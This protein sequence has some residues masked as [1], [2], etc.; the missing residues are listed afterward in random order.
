[1]GGPSPST[2]AASR[3]IFRSAAACRCFFRFADTAVF[4]RAALLF[5]F[6][7]R[8]ARDGS[9]STADALS[10]SD[11]LPLIANELERERAT[12]RDTVF[13]IGANGAAPESWGPVLAAEDVEKLGYTVGKAERLHLRS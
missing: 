3:A 4:S 7:R 12:L 5:W 6:V 1:M 8:R 11:D 2:C 9:L 10:T 13:S